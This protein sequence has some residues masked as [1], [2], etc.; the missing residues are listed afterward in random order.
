MYMPDSE[1]IAFITEFANYCYNIMPFGLK[2]VSATYRRLMNKI[3]HGQISRNIEFYVEDIV[4]KSNN[5]EQHISD[6]TKI[7]L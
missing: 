5:I 3:F 2:N 1:K 4:F 6:L 7:F